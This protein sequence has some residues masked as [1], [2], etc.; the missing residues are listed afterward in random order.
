MKLLL[1][2]QANVHQLRTASGATP[3]FAAAGH[4]HPAIVE[5]L[6]GARADLATVAKDGQTALSIARDAV[7]CRRGSTPQKC[8][9]LLEAHA[10]HPSH[11]PALTA[12]TAKPSDTTILVHNMLHAHMFESLS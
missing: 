1:S 7:R 9:A 11:A 8:V 6:L 10:A 12:V 3:L 5:L 2:S 4:G